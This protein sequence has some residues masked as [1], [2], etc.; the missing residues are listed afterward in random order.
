MFAAYVSLFIFTPF[1]FTLFMF[2]PPSLKTRQKVGGKIGQLEVE[3]LSLQDQMVCFKDLQED[4]AGKTKMEERQLIDLEEERS[5]LAD[6]ATVG[7]VNYDGHME[8]HHERLN[9]LGQEPVQRDSRK[10][11]PK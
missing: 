10:E 3:K 6:K 11:F 8:D 7:L 1:M 5:K 4:R 2:T 9:G